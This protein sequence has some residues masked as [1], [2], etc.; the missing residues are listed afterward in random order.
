MAKV[1]FKGCLAVL[2]EDAFGAVFARY[3][4]EAPP[5]SGLIREV[6]ADFAPFARSD[7]AL[8]LNA[9]PL[10]V[11]L[12]DFEE[13]KWRLGYRPYPTVADAMRELDFAGAPLWNPLFRILSLGHAV[14]S[15]DA[16]SA[17]L[18]APEPCE[19]LIY[20]PK[21]SD[22]VRWYKADPFLAALVRSAQAKP[23]HSFGELI[24]VLAAERNVALDQALL[25]SLATS[26]TLAVERGVLLGVL[27]RS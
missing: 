20:R 4:A 14:H 24:P 9:A 25:E 1:A 19:L 5:H 10:L 22:E 23:G 17:P 12:L 3:L 18:L 6:I 8:A 2:G 15:W 27:D 11:D 7:R 26:L 21:Q 16:A 13:Q